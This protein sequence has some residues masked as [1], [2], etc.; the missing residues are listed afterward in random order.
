MLTTDEIM[1]KI[2][3]DLLMRLDMGLAP[4]ILQSEWRRLLEMVVESDG[5]EYRA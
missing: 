2:A 3:E 4:T 5:R 1:V